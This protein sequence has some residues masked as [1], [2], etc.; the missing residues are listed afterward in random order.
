[1]QLTIGLNADITEETAR[2]CL[3]YAAR[4]V[5]DLFRKLRTEW[6]TAVGRK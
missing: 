3:A 2:Q 6:M 5:A 1:M 4:G